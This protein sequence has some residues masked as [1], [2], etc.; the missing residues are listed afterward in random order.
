MA[1]LGFHRRRR[2]GKM[3]LIKVYRLGCKGESQVKE[4]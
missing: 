4:G 2:I 1:F 3:K